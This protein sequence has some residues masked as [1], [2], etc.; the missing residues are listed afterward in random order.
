MTAKGDRNSKL[1]TDSAE[2][3]IKEVETQEG[4]EDEDGEPKR[5]E[6]VVDRVLGVEV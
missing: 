5:Y 2:N 6:Y 1:L 4:D 3:D